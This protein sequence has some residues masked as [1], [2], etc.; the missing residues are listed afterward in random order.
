MRFQML[1]LTP[2]SSS[3]LT[4]DLTS[5]TGPL[6]TIRTYAGSELALSSPLYK[7]TC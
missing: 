2:N 7:V 1:L 4:S 3:E 6:V 5:A